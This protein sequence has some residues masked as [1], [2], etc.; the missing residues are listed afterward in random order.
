MSVMFISSVKNG[1]C[2]CILLYLYCW[3][4]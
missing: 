2:D 1:S 3:L 4:S